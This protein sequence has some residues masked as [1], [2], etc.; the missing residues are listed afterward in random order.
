MTE[1]VNKEPSRVASPGRKLS[2]RKNKFGDELSKLV[3]DSEF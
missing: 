1:K 3:I 2:F